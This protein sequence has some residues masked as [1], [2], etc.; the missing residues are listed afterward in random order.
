MVDTETTEN[1]RMFQALRLLERIAPP[2][3][4][5][6][7]PF[8]RAPITPPSRDVLIP[9]WNWMGVHANEIPEDE[10]PITVDINGAF[11][12]ALGAVQVGHAQ[13]V[14][15]GPTDARNFAG[16][17]FET[18]VWPGY[19]RIEIVRWAFSGTL[20]SP[21]GDS[22][23]LETE[24]EVWVAHPTLI[25]L[26][27]LLAENSIGD[28][29]ITD[30]YVVKDNRRCDFRAWSAKLKDARNKLLDDIQA[31]HPDGRPEG[32]TCHACARYRAFKEGY[33]AAFSMML[34]GEKCQTR[35]PDWAHAVYAQHAAAAWRKAW[36]LSAIGPVLSMGAVD[37]IT[38][39]NSDLVKAVQKPKPPVRWDPSGRILGHL[40]EKKHEPTT[41]PATDDLIV[42]EDWSDLF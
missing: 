8:W 10:Q 39:L 14:N 4:Y 42:S 17:R 40:K 26:L 31:S 27:E 28:L 33:G 11:L 15:M 18:S 22:A 1:P 38:V 34:T 21:L 20:V 29:I 35:R 24:G 36:R 13:L 41:P 23:R 12:A 9:S 30:S 25:L 32:C 2:T 37:E 7:P 16:P 19:Y 6:H 3:L 5:G